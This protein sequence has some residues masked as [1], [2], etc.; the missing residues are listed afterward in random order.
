[1][2]TESTLLTTDPLLHNLPLDGGQAALTPLSRSLLQVLEQR[3]SERQFS[4]RSVPLPVLAQLLWAACGVNRPAT[5]QRTAPSAKN[6]QEIDIYVAQQDGLFLFEA[7]AGALRQL[8]QRDVRAATGWQEFVAGVPVNL[9]Y[10]ADLAKMDHAPRWEQKL[11]AALDTGYISQNV[12]LFCAAQGLAT[13]A[14]AWVDRP[15]LAHVL[16]LRANQRVMLAQSVGFPGHAAP[17]APGADGRTND[18]ACR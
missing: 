5:G 1:M 7:A 16:G 15:V 17:I 14:R 9:V 3:R 11:Y 18:A 2:P 6:W 13:V 10:V 12:Y 8:D 4:A